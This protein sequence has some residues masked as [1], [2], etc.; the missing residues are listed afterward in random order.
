MKQLSLRFEDKIYNKLKTA[1]M[2]TNLT[3]ERFLLALVKG[4]VN[5]KNKD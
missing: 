5:G 4:G 1:K 2:K 3:W